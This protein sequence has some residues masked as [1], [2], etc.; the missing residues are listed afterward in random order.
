MVPLGGAIAQRPRATC[1]YRKHHPVEK[2]CES[3][4]L[5]R[6][7]GLLW[8]I[9]VILVLPFRSV[10]RL[11]AENAVL[12]QQLIILRRKCRG[13]VRVTSGERLFFV[14]LYR[15]FPSI[16]QVL[17]IIRPET[18]VRW[19]RAGFR[20]YWR[21][22]SRGRGGRPQIDAALRALI[23]EMSVDNPLWG[24]PRIHGELLKLGFEVAQSTRQVHDQAPWTA[25]PELVDVSPPP[26]A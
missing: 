23:R 25:G 15:W 21:W 12:R 16:L 5:I 24:A 9:V 13:R 3:R 17:E 10:A 2:G 14:Q 26:Y 8:F 19:H 20:S 6:C 4:K 1:L 7:F 22:K 11:Q 18:L